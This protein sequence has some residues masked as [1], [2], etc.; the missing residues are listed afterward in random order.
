MCKALWDF[1][2]DTAMDGAPLKACIP[3]LYGI[4]QMKM[5]F[6]NTNYTLVFL[7][8]CYHAAIVY[9]VPL[10][11]FVETGVIWGGESDSAGKT[12]DL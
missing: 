12:G 4:G 1:D 9:F 6:N 8:G 7:L 11:T 5:I 2:V 3:Y 10:Y